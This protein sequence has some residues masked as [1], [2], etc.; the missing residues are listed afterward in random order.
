MQMA[1]KYV[2]KENRPGIDW[3]RA[4]FAWHKDLLSKRMCQNISKRHA[5]VSEEVVSAFFENL[6]TT[7]EGVPPA[8]IV[9]Y[10]ETSVVDDPKGQLQIFQRGTK[11]AERIMNSSKSATSIMF[12]VTAWC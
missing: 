11:H 3:V 8:N 10:D 4:F 2:F 1:E 12:A 5:A 7:L 6:K 9:N